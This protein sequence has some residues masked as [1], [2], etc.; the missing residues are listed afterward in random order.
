MHYVNHHGGANNLL[1]GI[2]GK[3]VS[4]TNLVPPPPKKKTI[5]RDGFVKM[6]S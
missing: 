5:S 3:G 6:K 1:I 2:R 4:I